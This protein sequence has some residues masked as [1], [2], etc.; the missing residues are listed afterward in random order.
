[1]FYLENREICQ[2]KKNYHQGGLQNPFQKKVLFLKRYY[3]LKYWRNVHEKRD[4]R[5]FRSPSCMA[6]S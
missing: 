5:Y 6:I 4:R 3:E 1:M 2:K